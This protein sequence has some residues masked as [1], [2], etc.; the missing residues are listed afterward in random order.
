MK[1]ITILIMKRMIFQMDFYM[2]KKMGS[3]KIKMKMK[4]MILMKRKMMKRTIRL[5]LKA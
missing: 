4:M 1:K 5:I 2:M 3:Y